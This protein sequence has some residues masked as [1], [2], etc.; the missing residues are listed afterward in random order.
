MK[1][2][3][4]FLT[5]FALVCTTACKKDDTKKSVIEEKVSTKTYATFDGVAVPQ[6]SNQEVQKFA[7]EYATMVTEMTAASKSG[8]IAKIDALA[9]KSKEWTSKQ[10]AWQ[11]K[12]TSQ[13]SQLWADFVT[14]LS[15]AQRTK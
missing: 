9:E 10:A 1:K 6:F 12:M 14:R 2:I 5:A 11:S 8:D 3:T 4:L 15:E 13:D 7:I